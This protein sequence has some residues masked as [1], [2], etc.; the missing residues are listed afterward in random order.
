MDEL[1]VEVLDAPLSLILVLEN[2]R[3]LIRRQLMRQTVHSELL[4]HFQSADLFKRRAEKSN[5]LLHAQSIRRRLNSYNFD[6]ADFDY[7]T[8]S[9]HQK[10]A[11]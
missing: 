3:N 8:G 9:Q 10:R 11:L 2:C 7:T 6:A 5:N 1:P 4:N